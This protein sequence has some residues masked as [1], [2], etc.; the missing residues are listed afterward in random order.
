MVI[1]RTRAVEMRVTLVEGITGFRGV[2]RR[3]FVAFR[4]GRFLV[5]IRV[6]RVRITRISKRLPIPGKTA[7]ARR[8]GARTA[9]SSI[10]VALARRS[11]VRGR[12]GGYED[13]GG[14][15]LVDGRHRGG[16]GGGGARGGHRRDRGGERQRGHRELLRGCG[17]R[18]A[19]VLG[20]ID[21][22]RRGRTRVDLDA[23][24]AGGGN[25]QGKSA[26]GDR[27]G[28]RADRD[29]AE[30]SRDR[31]RGGARDPARGGLRFP[32]PRRGRR[33]R[34]ARARRYRPFRCVDALSQRCAMRRD[35]EEDRIGRRSCR[36]RTC[37]TGHGNGITTSRNDARRAP[38]HFYV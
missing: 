4:L 37:D 12:T 33:R 11:R 24:V 2:S 16:R 20:R 30:G 5:N 21:G 6:I 34:F 3:V 17:G 10:P 18:A 28:H 22:A 26:R 15:G 13:P 9:S 29:A 23:I 8:F 14:V 27:A 7:S 19:G 38:F 36:A 1:N 35:S 32:A 25:L 31:A